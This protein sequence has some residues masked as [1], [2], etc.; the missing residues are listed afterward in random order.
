[1][2]AVPSEFLAMDRKE[3]ANKPYYDLDL[4]PPEVRTCDFNDV[5]I[6]FNAERAMVEAARCVHCPDPAPC[7]E[8]CPTH[9]DIPS[10]MWLIEQGKFVEAAQLY[11][12][13]SSLP[14]I[15]GRVCPHEQLCQGSCVLN[16]YQEPVLTGE[17][18]AF[19][20]DYERRSVGHIIPLSPPRGKQVAVIG[21][22]PA[23][24]ACAD[25]LVQKGYE[26]TVFE[27]KPAPGG[28]L[29]YGIPN[30]KLPKEIW[31]EKWGEFERAGV[32]F[33]PNSHIGKD[34]T[35]DDL[36][37]AGFEAVFIGVGSEI[38]AQMEN[39][40]GTG[41]P[42]VYQATDFLI[43]GNVTKKLLPDDMKEP[44]KIGKRVVVIGG[45]DTAS[46]CLRT[47]LRLGA[48]EVTCLYRRTEKEMPGGRKDRKMAKD[49]GAHYRFLTQPVKFIAGE[50]GNLA[51]VECIE[52]VLGEP[53]AKGRRRPVPVPNSNF[54]VACD[55]AILALGYWPDPI[56]SKTTTDLE[57]HDWGL[58]TVKD[59][60]T[61]ATSR[62]GVFSGGD[63]VTGPDIVVTAMVAGRKAALAIDNYL[64][65]KK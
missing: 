8:A 34:K 12:Q 48:D 35:I 7:M 18:E 25:V 14:E 31:F 1:M 54:S 46:D 60:A 58:I 9:N 26:V 32:Q 51:A 15:C 39:T 47:A 3:R 50:D 13:S 23:G 19:T 42:G 2:Q 22:G 64:A 24:L 49:E 41:L 6:E 36:F 62:E 27:S 4:R 16:K 53:D 56:I 63:C 55:T 57:T 40:P 21:A 11:H 33:V 10:A 44:L 30:F 52:M 20:V 43:R 45:G 61:G 5:V 29:V 38:D 28:L 59:P 17:L 37:H 65:N